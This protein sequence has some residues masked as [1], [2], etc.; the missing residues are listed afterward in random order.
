MDPISAQYVDYGVLGLTIAALIGL[1]AFVTTTATMVIK[2]AVGRW[3]NAE[4]RVDAEK[5]GRLKD[6]SAQA[7]LGVEFKN[8]T[9]AMTDAVQENTSQSRATQN[10]VAQLRAQVERIGND[11]IT[12]RAELN[13]RPVR[14][15]GS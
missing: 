12:M 10:E 15:A 2:W 3:Q 4:D 8:A 7:V 13:A 5:D 11:V 1:L 9:M 6:T 14:R